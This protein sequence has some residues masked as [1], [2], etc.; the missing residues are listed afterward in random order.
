[1]TPVEL[2]A[3]KKFVTRHE[4]KICD[5]EEDFRNCTDQGERKKLQRELRKLQNDAK[6]KE[7][8]QKLEEA[9]EK[10]RQD[11]KT[12]QP[13]EPSGYPTAK[14]KPKIVSNKVLMITLL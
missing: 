6:W 5:M 8:Q 4:L 3:L 11:A 12:D 14:A 13:A 10:A 1:M 2:Q 9:E 7:A